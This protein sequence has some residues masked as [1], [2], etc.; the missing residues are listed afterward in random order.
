MPIL[1]N[2]SVTN[3]SWVPIGHL[4]RAGCCWQNDADEEDDPIAPKPCGGNDEV[5]GAG[6]WVGGKWLGRSMLLLKLGRRGGGT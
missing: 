3:L 4:S 2:A 1:E 6:G 5:G